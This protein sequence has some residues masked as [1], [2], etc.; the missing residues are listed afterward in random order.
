M[1]RKLLITLAGSLLAAAIG[2]SPA[3]AVTCDGLQEALDGSAA[4]ATI[5]LDAG[6]L[7][8]GSYTLP[9]RT[10]T[11][12]GNG[13]TFDGQGEGRPL[14]GD[15]VGA[16]V[17][18]DATFRDGRS[19]SSGGGAIRLTGASSPT[20][21]DVVFEDNQSSGAGGAV[22]IDVNPF[23]E[24]TVNGAFPPV[25]I[26]GSE[27]TGNESDGA[28]GG[29][30]VAGLFGALVIEDTDFD[31]NHAITAGGGAAAE[32]CGTVDLAGNTFT[33]NRVMGETPRLE[34]TNGGLVLGEALGGG[35]ALRGGFCASRSTNGDGRPSVQQEDN[36]FE[37]NTL[38]GSRTDG[39]GEWVATNDT[40]VSIG[41]VFHA[42]EGEGEGFGGGLYAEGDTVT[43]INTVATANALNGGSG[44]GINVSADRG[45]TDLEV[46][47]GTIAGNGVGEGQGSGIYGNS[48]D[49]LTLHN[50]IVSGNTGGPEVSGFT[51]QAGLTNGEAAGSRDVRSTLLCEGTAAAPGAGNICADPKLAD[52]PGGD[53]HQTAAS[54]TLDKGSQPL[55][56]FLADDYEG[57]D[58]R[59]DADGDGNAAPDMGADEAEP[60]TTTP[61]TG[62][63]QPQTQQPAPSGGVLGTQQRSCVSRRSFRI[64]LRNRGQKVVKATVFVNGKRVKVLRGKRLTSRVNLKGLPKG[65]FTVRIKLKLAN[66]KTISGVRRYRTC[67][68]ARPG[69]TPR[70]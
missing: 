63:P 67:T 20:I 22:S 70:V 37:G 42:N 16:T 4:G 14:E 65:R 57:D 1:A 18:R 2:A 10:I 46:I 64:R 66:G 52:V 31:G 58:R 7:C 33:G 15:D 69:G 61:P 36:L 53:A 49:N 39:G 24:N 34:R 35:L 51:G 55:S 13:A 47:H 21:E 11:L 26:L 5:T 44:G 59:L 60:F 3:S 54:P 68:K 27:F 8:D 62:Q 45:S 30:S 17:I 6:S 43:L 9:S 32:L 25:R 12:D 40:I 23:N 41:D 29:L 48:S 38:V 28:G 19:D 56:S 50:S